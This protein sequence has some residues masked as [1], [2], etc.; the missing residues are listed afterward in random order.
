MRTA[1]VCVMHPL[2]LTVCTRHLAQPSLASHCLL[3]GLAFPLSLSPLTAFTPLAPP[4]SRFNV[5]GVFCRLHSWCRPYNQALLLYEKFIYW[6]DIH[7][8]KDTRSWAPAGAW[9]GCEPSTNQAKPKREQWMKMKARADGWEREAGEREGE[10]GKIW[11][12]ARRA[13]GKGERVGESGERTAKHGLLSLASNLM[14]P[15]SR[16]HDE[17]TSNR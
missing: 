3:P 4:G 9:A 14:I 16:L 17:K 7:Q 2:F 8:N 6:L 12:G 5:T 1:C 10:A 11:D 15:I 13:A